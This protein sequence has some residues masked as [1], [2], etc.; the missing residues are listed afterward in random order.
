MSLIFFLGGGGGG[1]VQETTKKHVQLSKNTK[2]I[3]SLLN[4][5]TCLKRQPKNRQ[6][7][8]QIVADQI[9]SV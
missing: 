5:K 8:G 7:K 6:N 3:M 1:G 2:D 9:Q 4:S